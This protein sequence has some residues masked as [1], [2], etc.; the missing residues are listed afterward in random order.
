MGASFYGTAQGAPLT[1]SLKGEESN[2]RTKNESDR[3]FDYQHGYSLFADR[4]PTTVNLTAI[5]LAA[6]LLHLR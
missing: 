2:E 6:D 5:V 3:Q 1:G 4:D